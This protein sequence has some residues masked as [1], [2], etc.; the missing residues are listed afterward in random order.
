VQI[1]SFAARKP[2]QLSGGQKQRVALARALVNEP[3]VLLLDEPLGALDLQLRKELQTELREL[4][5]RLGITFLCVT[6]DQ[7]EALALSDRIAV[8]RGGRVEQIGSPRDLYEHPRTR[9]VSGFLGSCNLLEATVR[10]RQRDS[11]IVETAAGVLRVEAPSTSAGAPR[12]ALTLALRPEKVVLLPATEDA[13]EN[14]LRTRIQSAIYVG[15]E[16]RY[17]LMAGTLPL[18]AV[19]LNL[20]AASNLAAGEEA[21]AYL[22]PSAFVV[23]DD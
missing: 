3:R 21:V 4:Q 8:M 6:H 2:A 15:A 17:L 9:F 14:R 20:G 23:L 11:L 16:S 7:E 13:G 10:E 12:S 22:P 5:R 18:R 19:A 1:A